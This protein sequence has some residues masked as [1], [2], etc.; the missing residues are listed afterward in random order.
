MEKEKISVFV[1]ASSSSKPHSHYRLMKNIKPIEIEV[2]PIGSFVYSLR[3]GGIIIGKI[4]DYSFYRG[5]F[6]GYVLSV[7]ENLE[8]VD[9]KE[10]EVFGTLQELKD[11][12][13]CF[14]DIIH[15][16]P[17]IT[18][19]ITRYGTKEVYSSSY[20]F[21]FVYKDD[22][23]QNLSRYSDCKIKTL[24]EKEIIFKA[25]IFEIYKSEKGP[26]WYVK[27]LVTPV[28]SSYEFSYS[29]V[30]ICD[31]DAE[32]E[33]E[34]SKGTTL[35]ELLYRKYNGFVLKKVQE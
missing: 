21:P 6:Y 35:S 26:L 11:Y 8:H 7:G 16:S 32:L 9:R 28:H 3:E 31:S 24:V 27:Y 20:I 1:E 10:E 23:Y 2:Y 17:D 14:T 25:I 29:G 12:I 15:Y 19:N 22:F 34:I 4:I 33:Q 5:N 13:A 30:L 18:E